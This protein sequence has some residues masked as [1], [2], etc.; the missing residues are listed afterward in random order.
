MLARACVS[1]V[2]A[3][4]RAAAAGVR[5]AAASAGVARPPRVARWAA[6]GA[7]SQACARA[8][9]APCGSACHDGQARF[10][11]S[12][13]GAWL[14]GCGLWVLRAWRVRWSV[15][16]APV[17]HERGQQ[18]RR[19]NGTACIH[20]CTGA[21]VQLSR[22]RLAA[23]HDLTC[24]LPPC[25]A[26][27]PLPRPDDFDDDDLFASDS[28]GAAGS[29][30]AE[31]QAERQEFLERA[32]PDKALG[33]FA[34]ELTQVDFSERERRR[35]RDKVRAVVVHW[36][37]STANARAL[38]RR[39]C[40]AWVGWGRPVAL[41][42]STC[43]HTTLVVGVHRLCSRAC[44]VLSACLAACV[45]CCLL[46]CLPCCLPGQVLKWDRNE[47]TPAQRARIKTRIGEASAFRKF[48][49]Y[50]FQDL[51]KCVRRGC[52]AS[53]ARVPVPAPLALR[54]G[55]HRRP[56]V[57]PFPSPPAAPCPCFS[58]AA[59]FWTPEDEFNWKLDAVKPMTTKDMTKRRRG[60][61]LQDYCVF[62]YH[63]TSQM[64]PEVRPCV[65]APL[66]PTLVR[67][68]S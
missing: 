18:C 39:R 27:V 50:T 22:G 3:A 20:T 54:T 46:A 32:G 24:P 30:R 8:G 68:R 53:Y 15:G 42:S 28:E 36:W 31:A 21:C 63:G 26:C 19:A 14:H 40:G 58:R 64:R 2:L 55:T 56:V 43:A 67:G 11:S 62:C 13:V 4:P 61:L 9:A 17:Q 44:M 23:S 16:T 33:Y 41:L 5:T 35:I 25:C 10:A 29:P 65:P 12:N 37:C 38:R 48:D 1:A 60:G 57:V 52:S 66:P 45:P 59:E 34:D 51:Q 6:A 49:P 47:P 7:R